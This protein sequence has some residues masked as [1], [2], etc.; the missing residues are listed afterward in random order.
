[1]KDILS[2]TTAAVTAVETNTSNQ[3]STAST[4]LENKVRNNIVAEVVKDQVGIDDITK[5][6]TKS[7]VDTKKL[8]LEGKLEEQY[9][10][11]EDIAG[12]YQ[13]ASQVASKALETAVDIT[14][15]GLKGSF[16]SIWKNYNPDNMSLGYFYTKK[17]AGDGSYALLWN[18]PD[19]GGSQYYN[20]GQDIISYVGTNDGGENDIC[21][22]IYSK[23]FSGANCSE[24]YDS[25]TGLTEVSGLQK[26]EGVRINVNPHGAYYTKGTVA[27][28]NGGS[29]ENEIATI[30]DVQKVNT[31]LNTH[32]GNY[33]YLRNR[34]TELETLVGTLQEALAKAVDAQG[35][36]IYE[37]PQS[38]ADS[39]VDDDL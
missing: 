23:S 15:A 1:M 30:Q 2:L 29:P 14:D 9:I 34:L 20:K 21:V 10:T 13:T 12:T 26:N 39:S 25:S 19:G 31:A 38:G 16:N 37:I 6:A 5:L 22:Q 11:A 7:Y 33:T 8:E 36:T 27:T 32:V 18:E 17:I 4:D 3:V 35:N 28:A 24:S